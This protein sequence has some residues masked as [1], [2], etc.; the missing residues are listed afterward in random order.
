MADA[1]LKKPREHNFDDPNSDFTER[2]MHGI[3]G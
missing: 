1:I 2:V 3:G